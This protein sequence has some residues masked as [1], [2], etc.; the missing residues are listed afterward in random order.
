MKGRDQSEDLGTDGSI[1]LKW[2][3]EK[4]VGK[5]W[6]GFIWVRIGTNDRLL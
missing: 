2:I 3:L 1:I 5:V 4:E 6:T